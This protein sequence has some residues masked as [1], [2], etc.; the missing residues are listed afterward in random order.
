VKRFLIPFLIF[1]IVFF[2]YFSVATQYTFKPKWALDYFNQFAQ[3][4]LH[5]RL[6][7]PQP[8]GTYD[9]A[10]YKG[11]WYLQWGFLPSL[12]L[13]PFQF[14][15]GRFIPTIY[16]NVCIASINVVLFYLL[17][18]R[19]KK[20]FLPNLSLFGILLF[21]VLFAFGT[22]HF[23]IGTLGGVWHVSQMTSFF[24]SLLALY[25]IFKKERKPIDYIVSAILYSMSL[26]GRPTGFLLIT[27][28]IFL[29]LWEVFYKED[30]WKQRFYFLKKACI[31]FGLPILIFGSIFLLYNY[32]RFN[33]IFEYGYSYLSDQA[34]LI[35]QRG[36]ISSVSNIPQNAWY[37]FFETPNLT[38]MNGFRLNFNLQ[39]NSIFFLTPP[40]LAI[41]LASPIGKK[42]RDFFVNPYITSLWFASIITTVPILM[43]F[44]SGW[45]QF[46]YRYSLDIT[47]LLLLLS[48]FGIKG[49][50]N[51]L[52]LFGILF[53]VGMHLLGIH[54]L[55]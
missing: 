20:E 48:L 47:P 46:G 1:S 30:V 43:H 3:S 40:L 37:M 29:Y 4:L 8:Q 34:S 33:N 50:I 39:G 53:A 7:L 15:L 5:F 22:T 52:Y 17:L 45:M 11:S 31:I 36:S 19:V 51:V 13:I 9:L 49:K 18:K 10:Y 35:K 25:I 38:F 16:I 2:V 23:Y 21:I 12:L 42:G 14:L 26:I 24:L 6:D 54:A 55:M 27:L 41:F 28:P 44:S 32:L